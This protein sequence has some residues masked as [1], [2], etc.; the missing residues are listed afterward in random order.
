MLLQAV[1]KVGRRLRASETR[2]LMITAAVIGVLGGIGA[3]L[4][5][6]LINLVQY[7]AYGEWTYSLALFDKLQWWHVAL[8]PA[9]GG[10]VIAPI[11]CYF[12]RETKGHGVPEVMEAVALKQGVIR[13]RIVAAKTLASA[14]SIGTGA[15]VGREGPIVQIGSAIGSTLGQILNV[16]RSRLRTMVGCGAAAGIAAT[17]N[18]PVAGVLFSLEI[19]LGDFGVRRF[20]P[21]VI[22][23]VIAT[24]TSHHFLGNTP[25]FAIAVKYEMASPF[26]LLT[27]SVL[28][29]VAG[30]VA[31]AFIWMVYCSEDAF[32]RLRI[33]PL[34][35]P[36]LGGLL[37]GL[38]GLKF[39]HIFGVGYETIEMALNQETAWTFL[40]ILVGVKLAATSLT[41]GSG[42]SGGIFAPSLFIGAVLGGALGHVFHTLFPALTAES[43]AYALVG[44][45]A[46]VSAATHAPLT[47]IMIIFEMTNDYKIILPLMFACII[48][49]VVA[50]GLNRNSIYTM[51][52]VRRG[53]NIRK[54]RDVNV[55]ASLKVEGVVSSDHITIDEGTHLGAMLQLMVKHPNAYFYV[56]DPNKRLRGVVA[57]DDLRQV[58]LDGGVLENLLIAKDVM[59]DNVPRVQPSDTLDRVM[60]LFGTGEWDELPVVDGAGDGVLAGVVTRQSLIGAYNSEILKR[61]AVGEVLGGISSAAESGPVLLSDGVAI[62]EVEAPGWMVGKTLAA[63]NL[64]QTHGVQVLMINPSQE[65][66]PVAEPVQLVP[67]PDYAI[68]LGDNLLVMG[69]A[70][71]LR[72]IKG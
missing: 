66:A 6:Q 4:F 46:V 67:R 18:A 59:R 17:F 61:D 12:A 27:Y 36:V 63:L 44:M 68:Q 24:A 2:F 64:R 43:G 70:G 65:G 25:A 1:K 41:L 47:S 56:T 54:G 51:K 32:E 40:L 8:V 5:R 30:L 39:P 16:S 21:I 49:N 55:L 3:I 35:K 72:E 38:I 20:T 62:T 71:A 57:V 48:G 52:L 26:E 11:V 23:S 53:V 13:K 14:V 28:G 31:L 42:G 9:A 7:L 19:I 37:I 50:S 10:L 22:S 15:S 60:L 34:A 69:D 45:G 33:P 29:A 58:I